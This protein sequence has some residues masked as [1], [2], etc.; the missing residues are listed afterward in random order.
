[1][2]EQ[3]L[4]L[5]WGWG[6]QWEQCTRAVPAVGVYPASVGVRPADDEADGIGSVGE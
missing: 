6:K 4:R 2:V 1:M 5:W 3:F